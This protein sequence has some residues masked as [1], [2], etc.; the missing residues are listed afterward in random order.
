MIP[1]S[2]GPVR[3]FVCCAGED[4]TLRDELGK[5]LIV[6]VQTGLVQLWHTGKLALGSD[7]RIE[8][9]THLDAARLVLAL[10]TANFLGCRESRALPGSAMG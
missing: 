8:T 5:H 10:T 1:A 6:L 9:H 3:I 7:A 4:E 2:L